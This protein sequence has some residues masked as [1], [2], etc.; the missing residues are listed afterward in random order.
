MTAPLG[1]FVLAT[2]G[3]L[4]PTQTYPYKE[5]FAEEKEAREMASILDEGMWFGL[6]GRKCIYL[7]VR[8]EKE[9]R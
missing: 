9:K 6:S 2:L 1:W 7:K 8:V 5:W 3:C 4:Y